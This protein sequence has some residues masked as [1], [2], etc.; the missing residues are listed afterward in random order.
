LHDHLCVGSEKAYFTERDHYIV[1]N[2]YVVIPANYIYSVDLSSMQSSL[3]EDTESNKEEL[4]CL[5]D[6]LFWLDN[7]LNPEIH[8]KHLYRMVGSGEAERL[9]LLSEVSVTDF[10]VYGDS[11]L[12]S[13]GYS[14]R[15]LKNL[16]TGT[17]TMLTDTPQE[18]FFP[19]VSNKYATWYDVSKG[20]NPYTGC[21]RSLVLY[22]REKEKAGYFRES[23]GTDD[24]V[25]L[26]LWEN[27]MLYYECHGAYPDSAYCCDDIADGDIYIYHFPTQKSWKLTDSPGA[28]HLAKMYDHLIVWADG[29]Y[30]PNDRTMAFDLFG[31]D[32]CLHP[33][34]K[35]YFESCS[36][37]TAKK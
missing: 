32:L 30:N 3:V 1:E 8:D 11:M 35:D 15:V 26:D 12:Y 17:E 29:R 19:R 25:A 28:R 34:L 2:D 6:S 9:D 23:S 22:D 7:R 16:E 31:I 14:A 4:S 13:I 37:S 10:D 21:G 36:S 18:T 5:N 33:E 20:T 24:H 27:W